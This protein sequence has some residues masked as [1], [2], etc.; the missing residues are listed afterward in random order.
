MQIL[1]SPDWHAMWV[2]TVSLLEL[3]LRGTVMYLLILAAMRI[4]RREAG[5]LNTADLLVVVL[6]ADA[7]QN[8]MSS[9]YDSV[10]EGI[11]L[12]ATIFGWN[13][14][15]DW[16]SFHFPAVDRLLQPAPLM[17]IR[18]GRV[19]QRAMRSQM[20]TVNDLKAQLRQHGIERFAQVKRC[21]LEGDGHLSIIRFKSDE[22]PD[23]RESTAH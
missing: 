17:L 1:A 9:R 15:L 16:L 6:V 3:V 11:V 18:N 22:E 13:F 12:V 14:V 10:T 5:A 4:F 2:P 21:C 20:I 7:A 19:Q 23:V 8:G